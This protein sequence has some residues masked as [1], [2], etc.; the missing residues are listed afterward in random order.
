MEDPKGERKRDRYLDEI[1][2]TIITSYPKPLHTVIE[3]IIYNA[4]IKMMVDTPND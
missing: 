4:I 1:C 2:V 3:I